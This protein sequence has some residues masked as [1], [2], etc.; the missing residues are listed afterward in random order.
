MPRLF[1]RPRLGDVGDGKTLLPYF[2]FRIRYSGFRVATTAAVDMQSTGN[3]FQ[4]LLEEVTAG[5]SQLERRKQSCC[6][7]HCSN[8]EQN[9]HLSPARISLWE[10]LDGKNI[11]PPSLPQSQLPTPSGHTAHVM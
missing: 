6:K 2:F 1:L 4:T 7:F 10:E 5:E 11:A 9:I 8:C 3:R